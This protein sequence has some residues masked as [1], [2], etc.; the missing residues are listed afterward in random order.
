MFSASV[1]T[2]FRLS[3]DGVKATPCLQV[4]ISRKKMS[5]SLKFSWPA[6]K[7]DREKGRVKGGHKNDKE[8]SYYNAIIITQEAKANDII[9]HYLLLGEPLTLELFKLEFSRKFSKKD[10]IGYAKHKIA[11]RYKY[12]QIGDRTW[13]MSLKALD[14][15]TQFTSPITFAHLTPQLLARFDQFMI[16]QKLGV[17][18]RA[19]YHSKI[20]T[21]IN[22]AIRE[23]LTKE[24]PYHDFQVKTKETEPSPLTKEELERLWDI[25]HELPGNFRIPI[26]MFLFACFTGVRISDC[27]AVSWDDVVGNELC[28]WRIKGQ[29]HKPKLVRVPLIS[30]ALETID[31]QSKKGLLFPDQESEQS[32]NR[33][34][35]KVMKR[36]KIKKHVTFHDGRATFCT[37][38]GEATG[39]DVLAVKEMAGHSKVATTMKYIKISDQHRKDQI[40][41]LNSLF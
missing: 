10:F 18:T 6:N 30:K 34:L 32:I 13:S 39:G 1:K 25:R 5:Q 3:K 28:Y 38:L 36:L 40:G 29:L 7:I 37:L 11:E 15:L 21:Y 2:I 16:D 27:K 20:K 19:I 9:K 14:W 23:K 22:W 35:K 24:N 8:A 17:N 31:N 4:I 33:K 12:G 26:N 41:K